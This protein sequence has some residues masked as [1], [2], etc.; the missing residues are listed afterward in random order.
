MIFHNHFI[1]C[2]IVLVH[3]TSA[4]EFQS[5][6]ELQQSVNGSSTHKRLAGEGEYVLH[7]TAYGAVGD[8]VRDDTEVT[9]FVY[10]NFYYLT[11]YYTLL[12]ISDKSMK[13]YIE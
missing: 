2:I 12:K 4:V 10:V 11:F 1:G 7:V 8:G 13:E 3:F 6:L 5:F 9:L